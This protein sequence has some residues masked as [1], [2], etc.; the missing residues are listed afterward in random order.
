M[1]TNKIKSFGTLRLSILAF[2]L[3]FTLPGCSG[4]ILLH[5]EQKPNRV[6]ISNFQFLLKHFNT[7]EFNQGDYASLIVALSEPAFPG[8]DL[9]QVHRSFNSK[10]NK[11]IKQQLDSVY[12]TLQ[13]NF[14]TI[15]ID[16]LPAGYLASKNDIPV[17]PY[18]FPHSSDLKTNSQVADAGLDLTFYL[19]ANSIEVTHVAPYINR[20]RY[21]PRLSI[22]LTMMSSN[23]KVIWRDQSASVSRHMV[24]IEER[25]SGIKTLDVQSEPS[26]A[27]MAY[28]AMEKM[29]SHLP[30]KL[31]TTS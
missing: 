7:N 4:K 18:G 2:L 8:A 3:I 14:K 30:S 5:P 23:G 13:R 29:I 22:E 28:K 6:V 26:L 27:D 20:I 1:K 21:R 19:E 12:T 16:L 24:E 31:K 25:T 11:H 10:Q 9:I 17:G 15:G